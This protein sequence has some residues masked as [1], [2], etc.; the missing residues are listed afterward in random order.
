MRFCFQQSE[1]KQSLSRAIHLWEET[2]HVPDIR[3]SQHEQEVADEIMRK[4]VMIK[5]ESSG[6]KIRDRAVLNEVRIKRERTMGWNQEVS[7]ESK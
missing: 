2:M 7:S 3:K 1:E 6:K 5:E 4:L